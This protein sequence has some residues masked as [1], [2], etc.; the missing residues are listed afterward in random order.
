MWFFKTG[1]LK[2]AC[3]ISPTVKYKKRHKLIGLCLFY[4]LMRKATSGLQ[5]HPQRYQRSVRDLL[6]QG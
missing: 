3:L 2:Y 1:T 4:G 5:T 6:E